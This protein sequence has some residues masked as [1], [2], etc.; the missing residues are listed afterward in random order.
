MER[1]SRMYMTCSVRS[2]CRDRKGRRRISLIAAEA[3]ALLLLLTGCAPQQKQLPPASHK[4]STCIQGI[5][6]MKSPLSAS[7]APL[8]QAKVTAWRHGTDEPLGEAVADPKGNYCMELPL[9][10]FR[11]DLRAWGLVGV[12]GKNYT[13]KASVNNIDVGS[14]P[15][16]CGGDCIRI[17]V[18]TECGEYDP[19]RRY[20]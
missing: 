4:A 12:R 18:M 3:V 15:R 16:K 5:I 19:A 11:V 8:G 20:N 1:I 9:A 13:C 14:S 10:G 17:D 7:P 6:W 2:T